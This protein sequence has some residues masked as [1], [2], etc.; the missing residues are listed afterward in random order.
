MK[1][2]KCIDK[3]WLTLVAIS[4]CQCCFL[5]ALCSFLQPSLVYC[6][7]EKVQG[8]A[9]FMDLR[10]PQKFTKKH[11]LQRSLGRKNFHA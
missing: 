1:T 6:I 11:L 4:D 2:G 8:F 9:V 5:S 10:K 7:C 3:W